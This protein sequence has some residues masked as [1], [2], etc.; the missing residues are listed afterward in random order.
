MAAV[1]TLESAELTGETQGD[2]S[3]NI[4][5]LLE[6]VNSRLDYVKTRVYETVNCKLKEFVT[7]FKHTTE[8]RKEVDSLSSRVEQVRTHCGHGRATWLNA[9]LSQEQE[10]ST[11]LERTE[12]MISVLRLLVRL[13]E[14]LSGFDAKMARADYNAAAASICDMREAI[15][16]LPTEEADGLDTTIFAQVKEQFRRKRNSIKC[17]LD[18]LFERAV[19]FGGCRV[20]VLEDVA[21]GSESISLVVALESLQTLGWL[22]ER[23][24]NMAEQLRV[25]F[26]SY[27]H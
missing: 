2:S 10:V 27:C 6:R 19:I 3:P 20:Q 12:R 25:P 16:Q 14:E 15:Q 1:L 13:H 8:L 7:A 18:E 26:V 17:S 23:L 9:D 21:A 4:E 22:D 5:A 11:Q 24:D